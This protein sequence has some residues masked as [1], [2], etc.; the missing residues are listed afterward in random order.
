[1]L[2]LTI[3]ITCL[4]SMK[5]IPIVIEDRRVFFRESLNYYYSPTSFWIARILVEIPFA[6]QY[7]LLFSLCVYWMT[8]LKEGA[9]GEY[10]FF[11]FITMF[12]LRFV[13]VLY[14]LAVCM[15]AP[16]E[17]HAMWFAP[18]GMTAMILFSGFLVAREGL[19]DLW[20]WLYW[21]SILRA[22]L[23]ALAS[24]EYANLLFNCPVTN[25]VPEGAV[26]VFIPVPPFV[27]YYCPLTEGEVL[28]DRYSFPQDK[29]LSFGE[30]WLYVVGLSAILYFG[31]RFSRAR[32]ALS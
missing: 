20:I 23:A 3:V 30:M 15:A 8:G 26:P 32:A 19:P 4:D 21:I 10:F 7:A 14:G 5:T 27:R 24:N 22:P 12:L 29:W 9:N 16:T 11:F 13:A 6:T 17:E 25:G 18:I 28:L 1:M 31:L 2:F